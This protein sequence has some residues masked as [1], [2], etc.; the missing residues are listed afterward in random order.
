MQ[1]TDDSSNPFPSV[2]EGIFLASEYGELT[3]KDVIV[4]PCT[5]RQTMEEC[6]RNNGYNAE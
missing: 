1:P 3:C 6:M 2:Q 4:T 5:Q